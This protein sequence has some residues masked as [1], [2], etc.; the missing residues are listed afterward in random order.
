MGYIRNKHR[1]KFWKIAAALILGIIL[2][3]VAA[4]LL[5]Y[6]IAGTPVWSC[7]ENAEEIA[8]EMTE[9]SFRIN[10]TTTIYYSD[11]TKMA[12]LRKDVSSHYLDFDEI[13]ED[14]VN[15]FVAVEDRTFWE[16]KGYDIKGILR[17]SVSLIFDGKISQG[18]STITQ[19]LCKLALLDNENDYA[20]KVKEI[21]LAEKLTEKYDKEQIMEWYINYCCYA[22][23][24]YGL[25]DAAEAYLGKNVNELSLSEICYLCAIPNRPEYYDP[26]KDPS[27][28]LERRDKILAA[29]LGEGMIT[30]QEYAQAVIEEI[31]VSEEKTIGYTPD[32]ETMYAVRCATE[33]LMQASG[34]EF[35]NDFST[36]DDFQ[37]YQDSYQLSYDEAEKKLY[38]EGYTVYTSI[39]PSVQDVLQG[40]IDN[41]LGTSDETGENGIYN[42]QGAATVIDNNT[43]KVIGI[44]GRRTQEGLDGV[45]YNRA[46][47]YYR[48]PGSSIK[49]LIVYTPALMRGYHADSRVKD[50]NIQA[51][52]KAFKEGD[53]VSYLSGPSYTIKNAVTWSRNG[54]ALLLYDNI[55]PETGLSYL[56]DMGFSRIVP[57]DYYLSSCLGGLT[58][59]VTTVEMASAYS[60]IANYGSYIPST[61]INSMLSQSGEEL[62]VQPDAVEVYSRD[63]ASEMTDIM[64]NV[65]SSGTAAKM[66]WSSSSELEAAGKTGTTNDDTNGWFCGFTAPYTIAAWTGKDDNKTVSDLY[67]SSNPIYV[68]KDVMLSLT[69]DYSGSS[70]IFSEQKEENDEKGKVPGIWTVL[71]SGA[72]VR[73]SAAS[74]SNVAF[75]L[76]GG[77]EVYVLERG[78]DWSKVI[79]NGGVYYIYSPLLGQ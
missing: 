1:K 27:A 53:P 26:W 58:Y 73:D 50:V 76:P 36:M 24:I 16:N 17:A 29:M 46:F 44:V 3:I 74:D 56:L 28:A 79:V 77:T 9:A 52:Y 72:N 78:D 5:F 15:A 49:P 21:I 7:I 61:C 19:Q 23:N 22:N 71:D 75:A 48:Q 41:R 45:N 11:G 47:Q 67:G 31:T 35:K 68:W 69:E 65:I 12:E 20:R 54:C 32:D 63:A 40:S 13:P 2:I 18:G 6:R 37:E 25:K 60:T 43:R 66:N 42:L 62:Y 39:D 38:T 51:A 57:D 34:F 59:G 8:S 30:E 14:A 10:A 70:G 64:E 33:I 55:T 4:N